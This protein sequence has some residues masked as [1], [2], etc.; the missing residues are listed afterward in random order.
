MAFTDWRVKNLSFVD[1]SRLGVT[2]G[3]YGGYMTNWIVTRTHRFK[4]A[5]SQRAVSDW[6]SKFG[7]RDIGYCHV[8]GQRLGT[9]WKDAEKP[10]SESPLKYADRVRT[11]TLFVHSA[12]DFRRELGQAMRAALKALGV[13]S[14]PRVSKRGN[15]S[16]AALGGPAT[17]WPV[18]ARFKAGST[19]VNRRRDPGL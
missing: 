9:P 8:E 11:P 13:E 14:R 16:F 19:R 1:S 2:G 15:T 12:E 7:C 10:W 18:F 5:I 4:A 17:A 3:S 6:V